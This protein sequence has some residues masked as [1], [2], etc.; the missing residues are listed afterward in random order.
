MTIRLQNP[1]QELK[2]RIGNIFRTELS[3][4]PIAIILSSFVCSTQSQNDIEKEQEAHLR[5]K[6]PGM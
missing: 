6:F 4:V 3:L 1:V 2:I 5:S